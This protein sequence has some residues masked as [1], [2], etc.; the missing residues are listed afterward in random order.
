[1]QAKLPK[2]NGQNTVLSFEVP[3]II[4][5]LVSCSESILTLAGCT[6]ILAQNSGFTQ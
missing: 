6:L 3:V 5:E 4:P 1:M 2:L